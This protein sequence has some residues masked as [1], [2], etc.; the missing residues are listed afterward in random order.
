MNLDQLRQLVAVADEGTMSAAADA[1]NMPQPTL[2]RSLQR[3]ED[4]L[5]Q[6]LFTRKGRTI[7][8]NDAG[9]ITLEWARQLLRDEQLMRDS[10]NAVTLRAKTVRVG[11]VAPAPL[12]LLT[13]MMMEQFP[14]ETLTSQTLNQREI[15]QQ[16]AGGTLDL[17]IV[18]GQAEEILPANTGDHTSTLLAITPLMDEHLSVTLPPSHPLAAHKTLS[19]KDLDGE[20]FLIMTDIGFWRDRVDAALP[21]ATFIEQ[22]DRVV[23][24]QL[25]HSTP[26]CTFVTDASSTETPIPGRI[27]VPM[28]DAVA[29]ASFH[30]VARKHVTGIAAALFNHV[31]TSV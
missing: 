28:S 20:T 18:E 6:P 7:T 8:L 31:R 16:V 30:L 29:Q 2:S 10:L 1:L 23:F 13:G 12:W 15:L 5:G 4:E 9:K 27:T 19:S 14:R 22:R 17:G 26:Y 3:L 11:T 25:A 21:H 24:A